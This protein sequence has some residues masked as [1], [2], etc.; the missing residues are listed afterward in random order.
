M[1]SGARGFDRF[2]SD[3][4]AVLRESEHSLTGH[5][6]NCGDVHPGEGGGGVIVQLPIR[7]LAE[8]LSAD[9]A[10]EVRISIEAFVACL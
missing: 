7:D 8:H 3:Q 9:I 10:V 4:N 6:R 5:G 2:G 1:R